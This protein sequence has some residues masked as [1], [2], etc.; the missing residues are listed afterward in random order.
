MEILGLTFQLGVFFAIYGFI[1][2]FI[3]LGIKIITSGSVKSE[4]S[5]YIIKGVKYLFLVNVIFLFSVS[6]N[7]STIDS[8]SLIPIIVIL[9][10]YFVGKFQKNQNKNVFL[11]RMGVQAQASQFNA[12]YEIVL[13]SLSL[14]VFIFFVFEPSFA[15][16]NIALWF[17]V[18]IIDIETTAIIGFIFKIVG[19]FFLVD[20]LT[21]TMNAFQFITAKI[22]SSK[23]SKNQDQFDDFEEVE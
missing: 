3:D 12:R 15:Q 23:P 6:E 16:N 9:F 13:I 22:V 10:L 4:L 14:M 8:K 2:F 17:K 11:S 5:N 19:F 7:N 1:W 18:T 21:K 20:I